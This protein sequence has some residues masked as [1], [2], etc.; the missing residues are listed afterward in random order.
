MIRQTS[1]F[2]TCYFGVII[3]HLFTEESFAVLVSLTQHIIIIG[4]I[5]ESK[6][7][8]FWLFQNW[9]QDQLWRYT[10]AMENWIED[11]AKVKFVSP[12][13]WK[14]NLFKIYQI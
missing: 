7:F 1:D 5:F 13:N 11:F 9:D 14:V 3:K 2:Q 6:V 4:I 10:I 12:T 8:Y